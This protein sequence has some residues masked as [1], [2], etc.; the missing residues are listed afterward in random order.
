MC[1]PVWNRRLT[2]FIF[3]AIGCSG[4]SPPS[5]NNNKHELSF[6]SRRSWVLQGLTLASSATLSLRIV[7][8]PS[9]PANAAAPSLLEVEELPRELRKFTALAPLGGDATTTSTSGNKLTGLSLEVIAAKLSHDLVDG[10]TGKGGYFISGMWCDAISQSFL[11]RDIICFFFLLLSKLFLWFYLP[12]YAYLTHTGDIS[13]EIFRD[14]C[15]FTDPTNSVS[16]L[17]KYQKAL[18]ILFN[19]EQSFV[20]LVEPL[21][22]DATKREITGRIRSG[23]TL[24]LPWNP[25]ISPYERWVMHIVFFLCCSLFQCCCIL[26]ENQT[27]WCIHTYFMMNLHCCAVQSNGKSMKMG[28]LKVKYSSGVYQHHKLSKK[29]L[30]HL[31]LVRESG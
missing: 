4:L 12:R 25:K 19:P 31:F 29:P 5:N 15:E 10:S 7:N 26:K 24:L 3:F 2:F 20:E 17:R 27:L 8:T 13:T 14:D 28:W 18:T 21:D 1:T 23:G 22:V 9:S 11:G 16:S 30:H 6:S